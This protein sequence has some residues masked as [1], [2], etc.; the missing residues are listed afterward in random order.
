MSKT[1]ALG[2]YRLGL[3]NEDTDLWWRMALEY[4]IF[5]IPEALV[6]FRQNP[7]SISARNLP[8]QFVAGLYVQYRLL[9]HLW[10]LPPRGLDEIRT[11]LESLFPAAELAAKERLRSFN[12]QL[13]K[14]MGLSAIAALAGS[15]VASPRYVFGRICDEIFPSASIMNGISPQRFLE[16]KEVLW[17]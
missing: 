2:G 6:G 4:D 14:G 17:L 12:M 9:S 8:A 13:A 10:K 3:H 16:R 11:H 5:C 15:V 1:L 7:S